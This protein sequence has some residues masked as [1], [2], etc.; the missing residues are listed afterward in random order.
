MPMDDRAADAQI[1]P[2]VLSCQGIDAVLPQNAKT[3]RLRDR[4]FGGLLEDVEDASTTNISVPVSWQI[5]IRFSRAIAAFDNI[6]R[7]ADASPEPFSDNV[8]AFSKA[9]STS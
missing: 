8:N 5:G 4:P 1:V 2:R 9:V 3:R 7:N 6:V